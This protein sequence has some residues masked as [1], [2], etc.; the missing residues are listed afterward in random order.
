MCDSSSRWAE[1]LR[2]MSG[3]LE[4]MP[5]EEGY[6]AYLTSRLA[7]FYERKG[8]FV[9]SPARSYRYQVL[10]EFACEYDAQYEA[11]YRELLTY[12]MYLRE[13]LK[14]RPEFAR[15]LTSYKDTVREF[16]KSEED[17]RRY[18]PAYEQY[19]YKQLAR[20]TH[21]EPFYF[22]VWEELERSAKGQSAPF[23]VLF[24]YQERNPLNGDARTVNI[25]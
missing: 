16:Y 10:L 2:E 7:Q 4:E 6:P 9:N 23:F 19:D 5:G 1:A 11:V 12:D 3:R 17:T 25:F 22:P 21:L 13:N 20:M 8:F 24:D 14:S 18:L 15:D